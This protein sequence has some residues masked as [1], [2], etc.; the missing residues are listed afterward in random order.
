[1]T[2]SCKLA[3]RADEAPYLDAR[4]DKALR[5]GKLGFVFDFDQDQEVEIVPHVVLVLCVLV[6]GNRLVVEFRS[7]QATDEA[8]VLQCV[9][10][11]LLSLSEVAES[12]DDHTED[13][14]ESD[15]D[16]DEEE[17]EIVDDA[18]EIQRLLEKIE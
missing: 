16:H 9:V 13:E 14:I 11:L 3:H 1:M 10:L 5:T 12:V 2:A 8:R 15:D 18:K 17:Q 7:V 6:E 4:I